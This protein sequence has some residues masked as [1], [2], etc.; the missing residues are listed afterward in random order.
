MLPVVVDAAVVDELAIPIEDEDVGRACGVVGARDL[1]A[2][3]VEVR[4]GESLVGRPLLHLIEGVVGVLVG[5]VGAD[6][7]QPHAPVLVVALNFEEAIL[8]GDGVGAVVAGEHDDQQ[9]CVRKRVQR[10]GVSVHAGQRKRR[11]GVADGH[12]FGVHQG[13]GYPVVPAASSCQRTG[14]GVLDSR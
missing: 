3:V 9:L 8:A 7:H 10:P 5:V 11:C 2:L 12:P 13:H 1:L 14:A 4:E 6:G